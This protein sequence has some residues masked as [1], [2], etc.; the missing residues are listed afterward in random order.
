MM[1]ATG[2]RQ[3]TETAILNANYVAAR[4]ARYFPVLYTGA[5]GAW[6]SASSTSG[7]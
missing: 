3:A 6:T 1:G 2:I 4:L 7:S 5:H